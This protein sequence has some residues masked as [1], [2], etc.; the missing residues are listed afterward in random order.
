[1]AIG[2]RFPSR[3]KCQAQKNGGSAWE[4]N[5]P[6]ACYPHG[7]TVLKTAAATW[8]ATTS[9]IDFLSEF[10]E[11]QIARTLSTNLI[12][13]RTPLVKDKA[14]DAIGTA[15]WELLF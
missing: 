12:R 11:D 8:R 15:R 10:P 6:T 9:A 3:Y 7:S 2:F 14:A 5:P 13:H 1:M 4:S